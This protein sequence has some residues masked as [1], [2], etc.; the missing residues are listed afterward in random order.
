MRQA[1]FLWTTLAVVSLC[2]SSTIVRGDQP[3][4][5][6]KADAHGRPPVSD[7]ADDDTRMSAMGHL[8]HLAAGGRM[9]KA[10]AKARGKRH[11]ITDEHVEEFLDTN[12]GGDEE[13][14]EDGPAGGQAETSIAVN[15]TRQHI[16]LGYNDTR[17]LAENPPTLSR[18]LYSHD[19][20]A[21]FVGRRRPPPPRTA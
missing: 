8:A 7:D 3:P 12:L 11:L 13:E 2:W 19:R 14:T 20:G 16:V 5:N 10:I 15:S 4:A 21:A 1:R 17:G 6:A 9:D 18:G